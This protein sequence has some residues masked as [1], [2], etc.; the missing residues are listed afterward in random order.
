MSTAGQLALIAAGYGLALAG[1]LAAATVNDLRMPT[2]VAQGS[3]GMV[4]FGDMVLFILVA[5]FLG[6]APSWFLLRLWLEKAPLSLLAVELAAAVLGPVSWLSVIWLATLG[7]APGP[8]SASLQVVGALIAFVAIPR[9][10]LGPVLIVV[11]AATFLLVRAGRTRA[12]LAA[13]ALMDLI[14][15]GLFILH[16]AGAVLR[17]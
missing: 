12:L 17:R 8:P 15:L 10:V 7:H 9:I 4:A 16:M 3:P 13:A 6:L 14:P 11:E 2:D 5:G 1:G